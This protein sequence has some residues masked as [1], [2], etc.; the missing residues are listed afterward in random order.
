[1][2]KGQIVSSIITTII[3]LGFAAL[4][5]AQQGISAKAGVVQYAEG[6]V[7]IDGTA[8]QLPIGS[9]VQVEN[10]QVLST[11]KGYVELILI[12]D[13]YLRLSENAS[14]RMRQNKFNDVQ[15]ELNQG[16]ALVEILV[17]IKANPISVHVAKSV[18]E[19]RKIGLYRLDSV[20][21]ALRVYG[22]GALAKNESKKINIKGGQM[23]NLDGKFSPA[24]FDPNVA[25]TFHRWAAHRS[26]NLC[27]ANIFNAKLQK[28]EQ[29]AWRPTKEGKLGNKD[30]RMSFPPN[31]DWMKYWQS[32]EEQN[33]EMEAERKEKEAGRKQGLVTATPI[34]T[35]EQR[36]I[37]NPQSQ[38]DQ[39]YRRQ[40]ISNMELEKQQQQA[41]PQPQP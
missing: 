4:V 35:D 28:P 24:A 11:R 3:A 29:L 13:G 15:L 1:M 12:P 30:Y 25:D 41:N 40:T 10:D 17:K 14:L 33:L 36:R 31:A 6:E 39:E 37:L 5:P 22:G 2:S 27:T 34:I 8:L 18:I 26:Y 19:I 7:L 23:V 20:P 38:V 9:S 32:R 21:G 16:S